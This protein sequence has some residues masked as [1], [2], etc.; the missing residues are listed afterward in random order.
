MKL[1]Q[2]SPV[3][4]QLYNLQK[5][6]SAYFFH[7]KIERVFIIA[8]SNNEKFY[9]GKIKVCATNSWK[10]TIRM[11]KHLY[12]DNNNFFFNEQSLHSNIFNVKMKQTYKLVN[13]INK[14]I[15]IPH[16]Q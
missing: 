13:T 3:Y 12:N 4:L 1:F 16:N 11:W 15:Q 10:Y 14:K 9:E 5:I 7:I 8:I 2:P 6:V